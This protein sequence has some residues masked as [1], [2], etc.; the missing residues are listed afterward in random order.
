LHRRSDAVIH[1]GYDAG[2]SFRTTH[3]AARQRTW[4]VMSNWSDGAWPL[5]RLLDEGYC[6]RENLPDPPIAPA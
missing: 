5:S 2:A 1:E 4:S 6:V 3:D